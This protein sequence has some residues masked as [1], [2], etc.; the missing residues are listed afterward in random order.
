MPVLP[1]EG[2]NTVLG[3]VEKWVGRREALHL[4]S[5]TNKELVILET[6]KSCNELTFWYPG[7][8]PGN[9]GPLRYQ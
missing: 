1:W 3:F 9:V 5:V 2:S 7:Y 8:I 4:L 6:N